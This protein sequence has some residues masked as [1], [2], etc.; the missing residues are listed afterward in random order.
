MNQN[1]KPPQNPQQYNQALAQSQQAQLRN[2]Q[3]QAQANQAQ[4]QGQPQPPRPAGN[5]NASGN[6]SASSGVGVS[7]EVQNAMSQDSGVQQAFNNFKE[8]RITQAQ[9]QSV[10][11]ERD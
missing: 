10:S 9:L 5:G 4:G 11:Q 6:G 2:L 7:P 3:Q 1:N 8:G